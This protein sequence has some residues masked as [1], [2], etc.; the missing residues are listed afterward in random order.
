MYRLA[1]FVILWGIVGVIFA[2]C[3]TDRFYQA[4]KTVYIAGKQV[5]IANWDTLPAD[6][7]EKLQRL[8]AAAAQY[9]KART[10]LKPAVEAA[11]KELADGGSEKTE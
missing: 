11:K 3:A 6:V 5:V 8:D 9:D 7:K 4:G 2:G 10:V 1:F